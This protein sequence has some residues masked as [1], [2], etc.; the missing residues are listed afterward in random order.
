MQQIRLEMTYCGILD[1][2]AHLN[3][4][5]VGHMRKECHLSNDG[6]H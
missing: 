2:D 4:A 6:E 1:G 3:A 5:F